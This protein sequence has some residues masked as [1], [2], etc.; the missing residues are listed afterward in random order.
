V[1]Y[2]RATPAPPPFPEQ[3]LLYF[4][5]GNFSMAFI[6]VLGQR[7]ADGVANLPKRVS[8]LVRKRVRM[9]AGPDEYRIGVNDGSA[10]TIAIT[11]DLPDEAR[12]A[13]LD[14]DVTSDELRGKTLRWD[15]S[16]S[17]WLPVDDRWAAMNRFTF[18]EKD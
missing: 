4:V 7:A 2:A 5:L 6:Q 3:E 18:R 16:A 14:L 12:L 15:T 8:D 1:T 9:V 17:A 13:L 11:A 10:A